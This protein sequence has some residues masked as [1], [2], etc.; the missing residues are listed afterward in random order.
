MGK[1]FSFLV[2][3]L[4]SGRCHQYVPRDIGCQEPKGITT[5]GRKTYLETV[6]FAFGV[7]VDYTILA[8]TSS[9]AA[10]SWFS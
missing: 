5:G 9:A 6:K 7:E 1:V 10:R 2:C 8:A 4:P 3:Y